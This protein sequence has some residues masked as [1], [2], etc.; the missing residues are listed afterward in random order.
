M[1]LSGDPKL[2]T[3]VVGLKEKTHKRVLEK[4]CSDMRYTALGH[5]FSVKGTTM[6]TK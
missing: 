1:V 2:R 6:S 4:F 5:E 3:A